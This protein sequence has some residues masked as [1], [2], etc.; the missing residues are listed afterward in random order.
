MD[1]RLSLLL[2]QRSSVLS[3]TML[4]LSGLFSICL[5]GAGLCTTVFI[6]GYTVVRAALHF[7]VLDLS[8]LTCSV[9]G[10]DIYHVIYPDWDC[11]SL[12]EGHSVDSV[13]ENRIVLTKLGILKMCR[14]KQRY[15]QVFDTRCCST[16]TVR[17]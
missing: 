17:L 10:C 14:G 12:L 13:T 6:F 7:T 1:W 5:D 11:S 9:T 4:C 16:T 3:S 15:P 8:L 2:K